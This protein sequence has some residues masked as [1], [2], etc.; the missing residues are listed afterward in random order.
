[1]KRINL[2]QMKNMSIDNLIESYRNGYRLEEHAPITSLSYLP[3][4][5]NIHTLQGPL[6]DPVVNF[7][8]VT[9]SIGYD[10]AATSIILNT[11]EGSKL[12]DP[13]SRAFNL[14]WWNSAD[15]PDPSDDPNKEI[16][17]CT[18]R[19][20]DTL[21]VTR[22][23]EGTSASI[24]NLVGKTYKMILSPTAKMMSDISSAITARVVKSGDT[25]TGT[26]N[27]PTNGLIVGTNQLVT[28]GGNVGI[29][30]A[31]PTSLLDVNGT[32]QLRG[33]I[34]GTGLT[35]DAGS[36]VGIGTTTP[37]A[38]IQVNG[39]LSLPVV[40]K[41]SGY[42]LTI[43]DYLCICDAA[44]GAFTITLPA[45]SGIDGRIYQ[46]KKIDSSTNIVTVD[47]NASET[48]DGALTFLI[49]SQYDSITVQTNGTNW[50]II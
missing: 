8:K 39:S 7:G 22:S 31:T 4:F 46:I 20:I 32:V 11:N 21:T 35:V 16:V 27:L 25:M 18:A 17:R 33:I 26:L 48:I 5:S 10:A 24:K 29:G 40:T 9:V 44:S 34:G 12:P 45:T 14:V 15:Y 43:S 13:S 30:I 36:K 3:N 19:T 37:N 50:Y 1:M 28:Y 38:R 49:T 42:T 41:T 47:G 2:D 6:L 23:Q